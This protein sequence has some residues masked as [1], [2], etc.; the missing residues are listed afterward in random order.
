[1]DR[2]NIEEIA[3][4]VETICGL[5]QELADSSVDFPAVNRNA[6]RVLASLEMI[7]INVE[8]AAE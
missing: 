4:L 1:M 2:T 7:R 6:K 8:R 3:S 5:A